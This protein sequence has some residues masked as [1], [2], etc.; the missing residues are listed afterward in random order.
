MAGPAATVL[1]VAEGVALVVETAPNGGCR[2][3]VAVVFAGLPVDELPLAMEAG[4][5]AIGT[6]ADWSCTY[7]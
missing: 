4:R 1:S 5:H 7:D 3:T 6:A 2:L